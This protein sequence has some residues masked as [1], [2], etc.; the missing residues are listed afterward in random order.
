MKSE[1][2]HHK[3]TPRHLALRA[4]LYIR[5]S[6]LRQV[7]ENAESTRRQYA[8]SE[9]ARALGWGE[10]Q[11][12]VVDSDQGQSG[13]TA[14]RVG[15]QNL[16]SE[17]GLGHAGLVM[18]LEVSRLARNSADWHRLLEICAL[19]DTLILDEDGLYNPSHFNDRLLL[20]LKGTMSEAELHV[21]RAR[22]QGG[23]LNK[24]RRGELKIPLPIGYVYDEQSRVVLDPDAQVQEAIRRLFATFVRVG[25]ALATAKAFRKEKILFP[26]RTPVR[27][28]RHQSPT[29]WKDLDVNTVLR[30][31]H[32]P[33]YAG[34]YCYGKTRQ[35]RTPQ[36]RSVCQKRPMEEWCAWIPDAHEGY[37]SQQ[38][39]EENLR[40]LAENARAVGADRRSPPREGPALLQGLVMCG[41]CGRKMGVHYHWRVEEL[42]PSYVC[43]RKEEPGC[44][45]IHG[46][47]VDEAVGELLVE[48]MTPMTLEVS[49]S[50]QKELAERVEQTQRLRRKQVERASYEADLAR[51]RFLQVDPENRLVAASLEAEWNEKLRALNVAEEELERRLVEDRKPLDAEGK[52]KTL[53][54]DFSRLWNDP[55]TPA[56]ERK[57]M[58]RLLIEDITLKRKEREI[59]AQ[60]RF[61]GGA[62][63]CLNLKAPL[64]SPELYKTDPELVREI[65]QLL[66]HHTEKEVANQLNERGLTPS[67]SRSFTPA[68]IAAL[69]RAHNFKSRY[70]RL[71]DRGYLKTKELVKKLGVPWMTVRRWELHGLLRGH[72]YGDQYCLYEDPT[73]DTNETP[74]EVRDRLRAAFLEKIDS[75]DHERGAV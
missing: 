57:R 55:Q 2:P 60:I 24:A 12:I 21:L 16:V 45:T 4:Y 70:Q 11:I 52:V 62:T 63:E 44:Q 31:L 56:R 20:G 43:A 30:L 42:V 49:L 69:R 66:D 25:S 36:G 19:T 59:T 67:R 46:T 61:K 71:R 47:T 14:D 73:I 5:Q 32:N 50:V 17:V 37:I 29:V 65:D 53:V 18:G 15:F 26:H 68:N 35:Y 6:T 23:L 74:E 34:I 8:L 1:D 41:Q 38:E 22:L 7:H 54:S 9:R 13:S 58:V 40:R 10:E 33:C 3:V 48:L 75:T 39:Y 51:R 72:Y 64:P 28:P 27:G